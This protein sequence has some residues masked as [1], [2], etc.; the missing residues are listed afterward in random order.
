ML[1]TSW[2]D[3][4]QN[5]WIELDGELDHDDCLSVRDEFRDRI[6]K[7]EGDVTIVM[8]GLTFMSSMGIGM[9]VQAAQDLKEQG[10]TIT[11]AGIRPN[12]RK[13]L[14]SMNLLDV[15]AVA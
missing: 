3:R 13:V 7:G 10:R 6:R 15:F 11:L 8:N 1:R 4:D 2:E 9:L 12:I 14:E 5:L